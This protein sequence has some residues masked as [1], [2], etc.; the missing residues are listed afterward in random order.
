MGADRLEARR[1]EKG[2]AIRHPEVTKQLVLEGA[3]QGDQND[4]PWNWHCSSAHLD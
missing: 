3:G 2:G 1:W 4:S